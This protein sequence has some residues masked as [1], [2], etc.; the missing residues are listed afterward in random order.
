VPTLLLPDAALA[1]W[2]DIVAVAGAPRPGI[3]LDVIKYRLT[4]D[5]TIQAWRVQGLAEGFVLTSVLTTKDTHRRALWLYMGGGT[6][7][8]L[9]AFR[10]VIAFFEGVARDIGCAEIR[11]EVYRPK[12]LRLM[13]PGWVAGGMVDGRLTLRRDLT[14]A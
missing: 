8:G 2:D 1:A 4:V 7:R 5:T 6:V 11:A 9:A 3:D 12:I 10:A 14:D 13:P